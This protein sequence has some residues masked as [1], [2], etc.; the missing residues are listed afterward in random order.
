MENTVQ[1]L[2]IAVYRRNR[3]RIQLART[4]AGTADWFVAKARLILANRC[5]HAALDAYQAS[6]RPSRPTGAFRI[7]TA[8]NDVASSF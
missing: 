7:Y 8:A 3:A 4:P 2:F 6:G 1:N 5:C